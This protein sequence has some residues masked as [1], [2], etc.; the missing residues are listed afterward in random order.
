MSYQEKNN[1]ESVGFLQFIFHGF[2]E[3]K[4]LQLNFF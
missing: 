2:L 4:I 1:Y 3:F